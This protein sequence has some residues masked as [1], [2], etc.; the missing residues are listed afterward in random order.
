VTKEHAFF[1]PFFFGSKPS[2]VEREE[3]LQY[4]THRINEN[5]PLHDV[6]QEEY[7]QRNCLQV[8]I[9]EI[10]V[11]PEFVHAAREHMEQAFESEGLTPDHQRRTSGEF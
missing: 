3:V 2:R 4:L 7:V 5:V 10:A 6:L 8:E 9:D 11:N 1:G